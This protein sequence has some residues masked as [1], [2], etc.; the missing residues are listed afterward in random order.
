[1][2]QG[3]VIPIQ[4]AQPARR[5]VAI[6]LWAVFTTQFVSFL[7]INARN[8]AQPGIISELDGMTLF[9]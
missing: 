2:A 9:S 7:F 1:M 5:K 8:I 6:G 3:Q 4:H